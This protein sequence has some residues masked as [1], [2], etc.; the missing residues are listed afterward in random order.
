MAEVLEVKIGQPGTVK[1]NLI[2]QAITD[3]SI[4]DTMEDKC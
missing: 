2:S 4:T 1:D 3:D